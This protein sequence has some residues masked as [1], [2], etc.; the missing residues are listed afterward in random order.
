MFMNQS[1]THS[2]N[3]LNLLS[4]TDCLMIVIM[5]ALPQLNCG[6][7]P[8]TMAYTISFVSDVLVYAVVTCTYYI[9]ALNLVV[10]SF[11][12]FFLVVI[13]YVPFNEFV[14]HSL[15]ICV[16]LNIYIYQR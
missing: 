2:I 15:Y 16:H 7:A 4:L 8:F 6:R 10:L 3:K 5:V 12:G 9:F 11:C 14:F 1:S 13:S